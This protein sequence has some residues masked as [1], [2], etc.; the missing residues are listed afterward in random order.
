MC[1]WTVTRHTIPLVTVVIAGITKHIAL[2][3]CSHIIQLHAL[4]CVRYYYTSA[5]D[6][7]TSHRMTSQSTSPTQT[8]Q[9]QLDTHL[10]HN[11]CMY[12]TLAAAAV[13]LLLL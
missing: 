6:P 12:V 9:Q 5:A 1:P 3:P 8:Q 7:Q 2:P 13:L 10:F 11:D 4:V